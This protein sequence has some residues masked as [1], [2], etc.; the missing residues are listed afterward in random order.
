L[1]ILHCE[2]VFS[3]SLSASLDPEDLLEVMQAYHE[4]WARVATQFGG[5]LARPLA[6]SVWV[7]FG[8]PQAHE[9]DAERAIRAALDL[10]DRVAKLDLDATH[11]L[12]VRIGIATGSVVVGNLEGP[13][14]AAGQA[15][16]GA[17][18][19]LADQLSRLARPNETVISPRTKRL[20]GDVFEYTDLG[21]H[22]FERF[23]NPIDVWGV[24]HASEAESRFAAAHVI[25]LTPLV[26]REQELGLLLGRWELAQEGEG[27]VVLM[28][29]EPGIGKSRLAEAVIEQLADFPHTR[30]RYQCLRRHTNSALSPVIHQLEHAAQLAREDS[31]EVKLDK[32]EALLAGATSNVSRVA[33]LFAALLGVPGDRRYASLDVA[34]EKQKALTFE[35]LLAQLEGL[36]APNPVMVIFEDLHWIDP[37]TLEL[38]G[39][40]VDRIQHLPVLLVATFRPEFDSPWG[41]YPH[42]TLLTLNRLAKRQGAA[43]IKT[44]TQ[45]KALPT[46]VCEQIIAKTDGVPLF[47]EE[48]TQAVLESGLLEEK[49]DRYRLTGPLPPLAIPDTLQDSLMARLDRLAPVKEVAQTAAA[50][51]RAFSYELLA[52]VSPLSESELQDALNQIVDAGLIFRHGSLA[53]ATYTFKHALV[54]DTAYQSVL[55]SKRQQLHAHIAK[56]LEL[57]FPEWLETKPELI[58]HHLTEAGLTEAAIQYWEKAGQH[59]VRKSANT[60]AA[61]HFSKAI[62][63]LSVLPMTAEAQQREVELQIAMGS[64]YVVNKGYAAAETQQAFKRAK[65]LCEQLGDVPKLFAALY[66]IADAY[67]MSGQLEQA[68]KVSQKHF[69]LAERSGDSGHL[70]RAHDLE[71]FILLRSGEMIQARHHLEQSLALYDREQHRELKFLSGYDP[72]VDAMGW[73]SLAL[74]VLGYPDQALHKSQQAVSLARDLSHSY[75][76]ATAQWFA[77]MIDVWRRE[78]DRAQMLARA[79]I[80]LCA[81]QRF[82]LFLAGATIVHGWSLVWGDRKPEGIEQLRGGIAGWRETR[83]EAGL[84]SWF[85]LSAEAVAGTGNSREAQSLLEEGLALSEKNNERWSESELYRLKGDL[86]LLQSAAKSDVEDC[87]TKALSLARERSMKSFELRA[88]TSLARLWRT[89]RKNRKARELLADVYGWFTEGFDTADLKDAKQLL[90][91]L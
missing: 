36:T 55:R 65:H 23:P 32:L 22:R 28:S 76:L 49:S 9:D 5:Y 83:A 10:V 7:Y 68:H 12:Q 82:P 39:Q 52:A 62:E 81:E 75:T 91:E 1:T 53:Q 56:A 59:A 72:S 77:M 60:E 2:L 86:L 20:A 43:L 85:A 45:G 90:D 25:R 3:A 44:L 57:K 46:E 24:R 50:I 18:L 64:A 74:W 78:S 27:K 17:T 34:P 42:V 66:G 79:L 47:V 6:D 88:A 71:G 29:G 8:Y 37:T 87:Y 63:L 41:E 73:L 80:E 16:V 31:P 35:A 54:Q 84:P 67:F 26:G 11:P 48:L 19:K 89:Q 33:P 51:G 70:L 69:A 58:A 30:L 13:S 40:I 61:R 21:E 4:S 14:A 38:L 15:V